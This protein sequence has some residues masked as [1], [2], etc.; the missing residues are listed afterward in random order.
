[1]NVASLG[2]FSLKSLGLVLE[3]EVTRLAIDTGFVDDLYAL[4]SD[5]EVLVLLVDSRSVPATEVV[6]VRDTLQDD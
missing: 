6:Q 5:E 1:M 3:L 2:R 4:Q